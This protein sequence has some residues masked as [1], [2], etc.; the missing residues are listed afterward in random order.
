[1]ESRNTVPRIRNNVGSFFLGVLAGMFLLAWIAVN[2][3]D[4]VQDL[5]EAGII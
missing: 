5:R 2:E 1:M 4:E 3:P